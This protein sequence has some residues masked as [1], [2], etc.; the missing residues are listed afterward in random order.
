M[1]SD[2]GLHTATLLNNGKVLIA[3]GI[4]YVPG[5]GWPALS[6]ADLYTPASV[7]PAPVLFS[8]SG[9]GQG[10]GIVWHSA[11]GEIASAGN[12]SVAGEALAMYTNNLRDGAVIPP[13]VIVGGR[14]AA[15]L[16]FGA[17]PGYPGYS[18]VNFR[19]PAGVAPGIAVPVR[20][21]Y[22]GRASNE[23]TIGVQ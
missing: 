14:Q 20:L 2:R 21:T 9:D 7:I 6:S 5:Q 12:P 4:H 22:L 19:V 8:L 1:T 15:V 3:G 17:A 23:L 16:Y 13:Q 18:Q 10:Q 11:T